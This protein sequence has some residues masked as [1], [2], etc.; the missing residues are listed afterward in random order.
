M[1]KRDFIAIGLVLLLSISGFLFF[2]LHQNDGASVKIT[3]GSTEK[4]TYP[5]NEN[6]E[7]KIKNESGFNTVVIENGSVYIKDA[8]CRDKY[9]VKQGKI[10]S[11]S[12]ICL[13]HKLVVEIINTDNAPD[14]IAR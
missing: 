11:G 7:I 3:V 9:C 4:G 8:D 14:A 2:V 1:N 5:L 10:K 12:L 13:P 6:K